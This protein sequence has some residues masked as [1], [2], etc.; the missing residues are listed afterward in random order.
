M[1]WDGFGSNSTTG[2]TAISGTC[3]RI[4]HVIICKNRTWFF[5]FCLFFIEGARTIMRRP[6]VL[7]KRRNKNATSLLQRSE[8][9]TSYNEQYK[10]KLNSQ[11]YKKKRKKTKRKL[12]LFGRERCSRIP[13]MK[14]SVERRKNKRFRTNLG[15]KKISRKS[16]KIDFWGKVTPAR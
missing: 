9:V 13:R 3:P 15:T 8:D 2:I 11:I 14:Q 10:Q 5:F 7:L 16:N 12:A 1:R 4:R 6:S